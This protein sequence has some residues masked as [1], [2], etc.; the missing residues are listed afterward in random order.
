VI[1]VVVVALVEVVA[2]RH[3]LSSSRYS[4]VITQV[5]FLKIVVLFH[6]L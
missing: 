4:L 6:N 5:M 3:C 1:T 2:S